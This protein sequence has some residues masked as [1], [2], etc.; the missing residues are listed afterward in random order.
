MPDYLNL[1]TL[2]KAPNVDPDLGFDISL[3]GSA[4]LPPGSGYVLEW[5]EVKIGHWVKCHEV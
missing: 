3:D 2:L 1:Q 5:W 4:H